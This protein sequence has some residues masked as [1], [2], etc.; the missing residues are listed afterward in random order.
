MQ[1]IE[2]EAKN[3]AATQSLNSVSLYLIT[4]LDYVTVHAVRTMT[5][6]LVLAQGQRAKGFS[7]CS[8]MPTFDVEV[9]ALDESMRFMK[10]G[11]ST[12]FLYLKGGFEFRL[13]HSAV[14]DDTDVKVD[15]VFGKVDYAK[16]YELLERRVRESWSAPGMPSVVWGRR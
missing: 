9:P 15:V 10:V 11:D 8:S 1:T 6:A 7:V 3:I 4:N 13:D 2:V 5:H 16:L 12:T 14:A